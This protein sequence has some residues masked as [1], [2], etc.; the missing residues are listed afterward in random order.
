MNQLKQQELRY[1][2]NSDSFVRKDSIKIIPTLL[3]ITL[4]SLILLL[5]R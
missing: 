3:I 1:I 4:A 5:A 2:L